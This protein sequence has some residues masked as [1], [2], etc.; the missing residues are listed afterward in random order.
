[1]TGEREGW[2]GEARTATNRVKA[3]GIGMLGRRQVTTMWADNPVRAYVGGGGVGA[4][5]GCQPRKEIR[6]REE[7]EGRVN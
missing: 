2:R 1:M 6:K 7:R 4:G 5:G 3:G